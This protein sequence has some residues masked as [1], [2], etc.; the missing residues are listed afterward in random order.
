L[1][2]LLRVC[3]S[4]SLLDMSIIEEKEK[5]ITLTQGGTII[6]LCLL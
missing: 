5:F 6:N 2:L 1:P 4:L 3:S